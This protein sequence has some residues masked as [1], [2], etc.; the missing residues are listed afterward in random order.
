VWEVFFDIVTLDPRGPDGAV[1]LGARSGSVR[2]WDPGT[3]RTVH[4]FEAHK[5]VVFDIVTDATRG[6]LITAG[7]DGAIRLW[8]LDTLQPFGSLE[9]PQ[10]SVDEVVIAPSGSAAFAVSG[11]TI[12]ASDLVRVRPAGSLSFDFRIVSIAVTGDGTRLAVGDESGLVH[13]LSF[14]GDPA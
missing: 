10:P 13:F 2:I 4:A 6:R 3:A 9:V 12:V 5:G 1:V 8:A 7:R 11:D 14:F